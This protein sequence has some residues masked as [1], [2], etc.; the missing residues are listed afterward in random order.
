MTIV[1]SHD[2]T[3]CQTFDLTTRALAKISAASLQR[4]FFYSKVLTYL[5]DTEGAR[6]SVIQLHQNMRGRRV[7]MDKFLYNS[8]ISALGE[9]ERL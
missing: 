5:G 9:E 4:T 1:L 3:H 7:I 6:D 8:T 2:I